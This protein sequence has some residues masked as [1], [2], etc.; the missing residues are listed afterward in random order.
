[1]PRIFGSQ[2]VQENSPVYPDCQKQVFQVRFGA[3]ELLADFADL[4]KK[5]TEDRKSI[6]LR[7]IDYYRKLLDAYP[8]QS[9]ITLTTLNLKN[10]PAADLEQELE[11]KLRPLP[12]IQK[13]SSQAKST[14]L[15]GH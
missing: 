6:H 11:T 4:M 7:G 1:M 15:K 12:T 10:R 13:Q 14:I 8:Q 3:Y 5:K 2:P 9:Y